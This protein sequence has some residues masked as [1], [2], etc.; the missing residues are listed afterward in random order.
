MTKCYF[1]DAL[2]VIYVF[3][4]DNAESLKAL[5]FWMNEAGYFFSEKSIVEIILCNKTDIE[6]D[7]WK[8]D[9]Q[10]GKNFCEGLNKKFQELEK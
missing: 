4:V 8:V 10:T 9:S 5:K 2:A 7:K 1:R 3:S 6:R